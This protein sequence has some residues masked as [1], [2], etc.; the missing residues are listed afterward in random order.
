MYGDTCYFLHTSP[1]LQQTQQFAPSSQQQ[2]HFN[3][4]YSNTSQNS[5]SNSQSQ[6]QPSPT[7]QPQN[8]QTKFVSS[9]QAF[10]PSISRMVIERI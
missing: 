8:T 7:L 1:E 2:Q 6:Q 3:Q 5:S 9:S 10:V 4:S